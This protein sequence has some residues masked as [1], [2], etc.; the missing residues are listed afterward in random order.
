M[1]PPDSLISL[2]VLQSLIPSNSVGI[3]AVSGGADSMALLHVLSLSQPTR[4]FLLY[5]ATFDHGLRG[6]QGADDAAFVAEMSQRWGVTCHVGRGELDPA[7]PG[8]E[9][10][11]RAARYAFLAKMAHQVGADWVATGHHADDQAETVLMHL[12]RGAGVGGLR[13]MRSSAPLPG[14]PDL[15]LIRPLLGVRRAEIIAYC[16]RAHIPYQHDPT[17]DDPTYRRNWARHIALPTLAHAN[18]DIS[19]A[20]VRLSEAAGMDDD[21]L[22][23]L[24][25]P[26]ILATSVTAG[27]V[28]VPR[29]VFSALPLAL[30]VRV[31]AWACGR[32]QP[33]EPPTFDHLRGAAGLA[34]GQTGGRWELPGGLRAR[35][36]HDAFIV[37]RT[38]GSEDEAVP[39]LE[40]LPDDSYTLRLGAWCALVGGGAVCWLPEPGAG[41]LDFYAAPGQI[42]ALRTPHSGERIRLCGAGGHS[43]RLKDWLIDHKIPQRWR[44]RLPVLTV[45]AI[46]VGLWDGARWHQ[47]GSDFPPNCSLA[48][49]FRP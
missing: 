43:K 25:R 4:G 35:L 32:L 2:H 42:V 31:V 26:A 13:G 40:V 34:D 37:E 11:A 18:P 16:A 5:V 15:V 47:F 44:A 29:P 8:V 12:I 19:G 9:A 3:A 33:S 6:Q 38:D 14:S 7:A 45:E 30:R 22:E 10:R 27:R 46:P 49:I 39:G 28:I 41:A 36:E 1:N 23:N 17:N 20:L 21:L 48:A 24:T